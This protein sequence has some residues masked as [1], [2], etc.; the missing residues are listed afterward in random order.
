MSLMANKETKRV[1]RGHTLALRTCD[2]D[3][4]A[5]GG[6][7][8]PESG[9]VEA[10]DWDP[11]PVCGHG[12][13]GLLRG[14]GD[15]GL[16]SWD[17]DAR[18]LVVQVRES[19]IVRIDERKV[20]FPKGKV[21]FVGDRLGALATMARLGHLDDGHVGGTATAG[22]CGTAT[23]GDRGTATAGDRGTVIIKW[24]DG[25]AGRYRRAVGYV[26][27]DGIEAGTRYRLDDHGA[28]VRA[29]A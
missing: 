3:M 2:R 15:G 4:K 10:P 21:I 9:T 13:H 12:L 19:D 20:K 24:W 27:E 23:A 17:P 14:V 28:F 22:Y 5:Y 16:L 8:W 25:K 6:F 7:Q 18:W 26:G 11:A 29:D 1:P